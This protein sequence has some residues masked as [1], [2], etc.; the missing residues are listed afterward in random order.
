MAC[1][2]TGGMVLAPDELR[3]AR[4]AWLGQHPS[5]YHWSQLTACFL[6]PWLTR[7]QCSMGSSGWGRCSQSGKRSERKYLSDLPLK[8]H[9][10][11][12][13]R[14]LCAFSGSIL[15]AM[16]LASSTCSLPQVSFPPLS[17]QCRL[18]SGLLPPVPSQPGF[19]SPQGMAK[20]EDSL[21]MAKE[22]FFPT[23]KFLLEKPGLLAS[24][25]R[26]NEMLLGLRVYD[27]GCPWASGLLWAHTPLP[28][29]WAGEGWRKGVHTE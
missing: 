26:E 3:L 18:P 20:P 1:V 10:L 5:S 12:W 6:S 17:P 11:D 16:K 7:V 22:A 23:Q 8:P 28:S 25:G 29:V 27:R 2:G 4:G 13:T 21:L 14:S 24:P 19:L 15:K 9:K